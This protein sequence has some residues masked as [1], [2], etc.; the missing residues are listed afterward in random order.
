MNRGQVLAVDFENKKLLK[1]IQQKSDTKSNK[2][3]LNKTKICDG[4][5]GKGTFGVGIYP[6]KSKNPAA[7]NNLVG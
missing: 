6:N 5:V 3:Y 1:S 2:H 4:A 7:K